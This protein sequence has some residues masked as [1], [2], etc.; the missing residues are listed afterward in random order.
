VFTAVF[1]SMPKTTFAQNNGIIAMTGVAARRVGVAAAGL[2][3]LLGLF[4]K[5]AALIS[6]VPRPVIGGATVLMFAMVAVAGLHIVESG[7]F[8]GRVQFILG[9]ALAL[10]LGVEMVPQ[11]M[12]HVV[13]AMEATPWLAGAAPAAGVILESGLTIGALT[14]VLLNLVMPPEPPGVAS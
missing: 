1:N 13:K 12:E 10:G 6:I 2:L 4:P 11:A 5:L 3:V 8:D 14:A 7:G 9:A